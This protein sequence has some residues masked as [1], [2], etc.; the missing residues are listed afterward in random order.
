MLYISKFPEP[1]HPKHKT[2]RTKFRE[3]KSLK[4]PLKLFSNNTR[5]QQIK[6]Y[7]NSYPNIS[8]DS[9][10]LIYVQKVLYIGIKSMSKVLPEVCLVPLINT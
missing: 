2:L 5:H 8:Q 7:V 3:H 4:D 6:M 9:S 10:V 1:K